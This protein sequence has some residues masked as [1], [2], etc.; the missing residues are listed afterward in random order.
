MARIL[1]I[2]SYA[3]SLINFR[4]KL[5]ETLVDR[6]HEVFACATD[7][8]EDVLQ[9]L[10]AMGVGYYDIPLERRGMNPFKDLLYCWRLF[11]LIRKL[12]VDVVLSYTIKPVVYGSLAARFAG[13]GSIASMI[14]GLGYSFF[15]NSVPAKVLRTVAV[16]LFRISLRFN[17]VVFFQNQDD[18]ALFAQLGLITKTTAPV[19]I[20]GSGVDIDHYLPAPL[21]SNITF[22]MISRLTREKGVLDYLTAAKDL[23]KDFPEAKFMLLGNRFPGRSYVSEDEL[24]AYVECGTVSYLGTRKDVRPVFAESTVFVLPTHGGEG[25]PRTILEAMAMGRPVI[26]TDTSGCREAVIEGH[27]GCLISPRDTDALAASM[28]RFIEGSVD[29]VKMS[30]QSRM[31]AEQKFD[32]HLVN[33]IIIASLNL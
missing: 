19:L 22:L 7:S 14:T 25:I 10:Q 20:P 4:G 28:R 9:D 17:R 13:V 2:G 31:M 3:P 21:P 23:K 32:V 24:A 5:L 11:R 29:L 18:M 15:A 12:K 1:M 26:T 16:S 8:R 27:N 30:T 6:G 33:K